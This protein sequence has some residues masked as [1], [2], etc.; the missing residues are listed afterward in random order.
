LNSQPQNKYPTLPF[1]HLS[2][3]IVPALLAGVLCFYSCKNK[4]TDSLTLRSGSSAD[5]NLVKTDSVVQDEPRF[6]Y[7][8]YE[9]RRHFNLKKYVIDMKAGYYFADSTRDRHTIYPEENL[10]IA[11]NKATNKSDTIKLETNDNLHDAEIT[12]FSDSLHLDAC[13]GIDW[14]GDSD[15]PM[16]ELVGIW[17]DSLQSFFT[18]AFLLSIERKNEWTLSGF[19]R[20]RD[21]IVDMGEDDYPFEFSLRDY[22]M[23]DDPPP[24]QYIGHSTKTLEPVKGYKMI[25]KKDSVAYTI[26]PGVK[27][28]VDTFY[29][30]AGRVI[31]LIL[32]DSTR[33]HTKYEDVESKLES[34]NAG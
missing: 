21:E 26:K 7:D 11:R 31:L 2:R 9:Q 1:R 28:V 25:N 6:N 29:R 34:D 10:L 13:F 12:D 16:T 5:S 4:R 30:A 15:M 14:S 27:V 33:F 32:P 22:S 18:I 17:R 24:V 23:K 8:R 20:S 19:R 3:I